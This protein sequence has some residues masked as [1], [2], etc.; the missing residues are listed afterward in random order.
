MSDSVRPQRRQP[1]RLPRPWDSPGKNTGVGCHFLLAHESEHTH[2]TPVPLST[3][4]SCISME[5][6]L[7]GESSWGKEWSKL[8]EMSSML[9]CKKV[10]I[11][12]LIRGTQNS[13]GQTR[14]IETWC[15]RKTQK[16]KA[17]PSHYSLRYERLIWPSQVF[18]R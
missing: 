10:K 14:A 2:S 12:T 17:Q 13:E 5:P 3:G 1:T 9:C 11:L 18:Q 15:D 6:R 7:Y 8:E 4:P 16:T